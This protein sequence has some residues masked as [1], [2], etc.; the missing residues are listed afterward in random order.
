[1]KSKKILKKKQ[2]KD[3]IEKLIR[4]IEKLFINLIQIN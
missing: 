3:E 4:K 2:D 1:M